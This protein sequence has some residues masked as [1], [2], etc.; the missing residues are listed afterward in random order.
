V[1][2]IVA[3]EIVLFA[4]PLTDILRNAKLAKTESGGSGKAWKVAGCHMAQ[5]SGGF[6]FFFFSTS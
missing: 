5:P 1:L 6:F 3:R 2:D 4:C